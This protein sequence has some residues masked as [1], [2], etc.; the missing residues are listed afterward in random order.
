MIHVAVVIGEK[1][2]EHDFTPTGAPNAYTEQAFEV[3]IPMKA[4]FTVQHE[5]CGLTAGN[6]MWV[7]N[8]IVE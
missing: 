8:I 2:N 1:V 7:D 5:S 4:D 6:I 3:N